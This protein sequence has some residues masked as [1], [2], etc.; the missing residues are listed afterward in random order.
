MG[1]KKKGSALQEKI[2]TYL[3]EYE[4]DDL[5]QANDMAALTQMCQLELNIEKIQEALD[6]LNYKSGAGKSVDSKMIRELHSA[7]R[8]ANQN[9]VTLQ[10][11]LGINRKKRKSDSEESPLQYID[12]LQTQAK[13]IIDSRF[14]AF[15]CPN[16][17]QILGKYFFYVTEK[18]EDGSID[19]EGKE[20]EK[21]K[22]TIRHECWKCG[23]VAEHSNES[24]VI[25]ES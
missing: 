6:G 19:T 11:E 10:Q 9:W 1:R 23:K 4:L 25:A 22:Y 3:E 17:G 13:K 14:T 21:Y 2:D 8:D 7:L 12:R 18:Q 16:C 5:N 20:I 24:I 15:V